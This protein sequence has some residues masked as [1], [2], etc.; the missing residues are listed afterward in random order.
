MRN[1]V[2]NPTR[3]ATAKEGGSEGSPLGRRKEE[4]EEEEEEEGAAGHALNSPVPQQRSGSLKAVNTALNSSQP[5]PT[6][7]KRGET[8]SVARSVRHRAT[9]H[10]VY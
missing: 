7:L 10:Y 2:L 5:T 6:P 3:P 4:K 8:L 1:V 9:H